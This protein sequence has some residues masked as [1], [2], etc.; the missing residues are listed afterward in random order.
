MDTEN[1]KILEYGLVEFCY[2]QVFSV[3][4]CISK[5]IL[6]LNCLM[7]SYLE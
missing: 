2:L 5:L 4:R 6:T 1:P 3:Q 7:W